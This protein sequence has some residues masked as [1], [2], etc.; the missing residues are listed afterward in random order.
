MQ[1]VPDNSTTPQGDRD[2]GAG[3]VEGVTATAGGLWRATFGAIVAAAL[4]LVLFWLPAEYGLDPTGMGR[5]MGLTEMGEI[6]QQLDAEA[7]A[8]EA[9]AGGAN[10]TVVLQ[11]LDAI[12]A[13]LEDIQAMLAVASSRPVA[14]PATENSTTDVAA[15]EIPAGATWRDEVSYTLAPGEGVEVKLVMQAGAVA[16]F[17]WSANGA[18]LNHDTHGHGSGQRITYERGRGVAEQEAELQ[19]AFSGKHGWFWR[20]RTD[21]PVTL[22]LR[23]RGDY[24][25]LEAP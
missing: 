9:L 12:E 8:E 5:I 11:R 14:A 18:V 24:A 17:Q 6:K 16:E 13:R 7:A 21:A 10:Q 3:R 23:T 2:A 22:T 1:H 25:E 19:A 4:I 20:N 15:F